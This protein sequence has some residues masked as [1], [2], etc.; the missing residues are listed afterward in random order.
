MINSKLRAFG[1]IFRLL[2]PTFT[3]SRIRIF[4]RLNRKFLSGK[5]D[6]NLDCS[7][8]WILRDDNSRLRV[9]IFKSKEHSGNVPG[10]LWMHGGGYGMG[11]PEQG[12]E[13]AKVLIREKKCVMIA[14]DYRLSVDAPYPAALND[15]YTALLWMKNNAESLDINDSQIFIGGD[16]AGGGLAAALSLYARDKKEVNIAFQMPLY[17]MLD[18][19]MQTESATDNN[20]P[21]WNSKSNYFA[22]KLYLGELFGKDVVPEYAAPARATNY[23]NLPPT[24]TFVGD[25]E[26]FRDETILYVENLRKV[27]VKVSFRV[28]EGCYHAFEQVCPKAEISKS[29]V[30]YI[31]SE[32]AFAVENYFAGQAIKK[33]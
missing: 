15:C 24:A 12:I 3:E 22:W 21:V 18:D 30:E 31:T 10:I 4:A 32:Y 2:N 26:P 6:K 8:K 9:C 25:L 23:S 29:A 19:R 28:Y 5:T 16:S 20:A 1:W 33:M 11:V 7:E 27:D 14:P 17:P 13:M